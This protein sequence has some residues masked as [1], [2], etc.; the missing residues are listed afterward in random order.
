MVLTLDEIKSRKRLE[1]RSWPYG[2]MALARKAM[3]HKSKESVFSETGHDPVKYRRS[4]VQ[5]AEE[6]S[7]LEESVLLPM[8]PSLECHSP[9]PDYNSVIQY[10]APPV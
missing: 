5:E 7:A 9:P 6:E 4:E 10:T 1:I 3:V 8:D 2:I